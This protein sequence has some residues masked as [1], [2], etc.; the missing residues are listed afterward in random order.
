MARSKYNRD[1][2]IKDLAAGK[3]KPS[4]VAD[5]HG[6][7]V[8]NVYAIRSA[9][10]REGILN[11]RGYAT[12]TERALIEGK[13]LNAALR[14][15]IKDMRQH[16]LM[17]SEI[18]KILN[19]EGIKVTF[20]QVAKVMSR[21]AQSYRPPS[22]QHLQDKVTRLVLAGFSDDEV[23]HSMRGQSTKDVDRMIAVA[24]RVEKS[25]DKV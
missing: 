21:A 20:D 1:D 13:T 15:R 19:D 25:G 8:S 11:S 18:V 23:R 9:A 16:D 2:V 17:T 22:T 10:R 7:T 12:V 24:K 3:L 4:E 14:E 5:K 6:L